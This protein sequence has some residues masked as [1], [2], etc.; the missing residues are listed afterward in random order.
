MLGCK[1]GKTT[2]SGAPRYLS[3]IAC[4]ASLHEG[5]G[6]NQRDEDNA[7]ER[8]NLMTQMFV[9]FLLAHPGEQLKITTAEVPGWLLSNSAEHAENVIAPIEQPGQTSV[10][11]YGSISLTTL[12]PKIL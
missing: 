3:T 12:W 11:S 10:R 9:L 4:E 1:G 5:G 2:S 7:Q 8:T 6:C